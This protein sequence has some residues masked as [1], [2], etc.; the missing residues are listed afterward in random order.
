MIAKHS[1]GEIERKRKS[2]QR[3]N[4]EGNKQENGE[5]NKQENGEGIQ[6]E[7]GEREIGDLN[8]TA[9]PA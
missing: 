3:V 5:G 8:L 7:G 9:N 2:M 4:A 1:L 6:K